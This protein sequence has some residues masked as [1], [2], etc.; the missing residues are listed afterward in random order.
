VD[1]CIR[2][3]YMMLEFSPVLDVPGNDVGLCVVL[4]DLNLRRLAVSLAGFEHPPG[5]SPMQTQSLPQMCTCLFETLS[6][7]VGFLTCDSILS[8]ICT[9][10]PASAWNKTQFQNMTLSERR[11]T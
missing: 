9:I 10:S 3:P 6:M 1:E 2:D 11:S 5:S 8:F 4:D 7:L